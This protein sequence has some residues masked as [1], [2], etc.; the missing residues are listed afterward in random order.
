[1]VSD[2]ELDS[3]IVGG[4][5]LTLGALLELVGL[6]PRL[7]GAKKLR[8]ARSTFNFEMIERH[9]YKIESD[10]SFGMTRNGAGFVYSF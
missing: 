2:G 1:M 9:G 10:L 4:L 6:V 3:A 8:R 7:L 5:S